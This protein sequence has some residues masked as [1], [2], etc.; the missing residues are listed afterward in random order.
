MNFLIYIDVFSG[1]FKNSS[2]KVWH[3]RLSNSNCVIQCYHIP[4]MYDIKQI[5]FLFSV[6]IS[7][8]LTMN[9]LLLKVVKLFS[10]YM[11]LLD[12]YVQLKKKKIFQQKHF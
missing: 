10:K 7:L 12:I 8:Y 11:F 5:L 9:N 6:F 1:A 4:N 2:I 3:P